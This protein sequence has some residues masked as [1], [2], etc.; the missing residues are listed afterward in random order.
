M[1]AVTE[2]DPREGL[3]EAIEE[4]VAWM[5]EEGHSGTDAALKR[6]AMAA[7]TTRQSIYRWRN[8]KYKCANRFIAKSI[9]EAIEAEKK[10]LDPS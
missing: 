10:D 7:H 1:A 9:R 2:Q 4:F 5:E 6:I 3:G 8:G